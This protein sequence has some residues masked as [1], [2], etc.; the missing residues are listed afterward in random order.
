M[1]WMRKRTVRSRLTALV[2]VGSALLVVALSTVLW[3]NE[4]RQSSRRLDRS[5]ERRVDAID[6]ALRTNWKFPYREP[7][8]QAIDADYRILGMSQAID[9]PGL[10]TQSQIDFVLRNGGL[11]FRR[12]D[13]LLDGTARFLAQRRII[14]NVP[15]VVV[16]GETESVLRAS[17]NQ[18]WFAIAVGAPLLVL[19]MGLGGWALAGAVLRPVRKMTDDAA[20]ISRFDAKARLASGPGNDEL[21]HLSDTL[22]SMLDR[23]ESSFRRERSFVDDASHE[24]RTP[25]AIVRGELELALLNSGNPSETQDALQRSIDEV[26]RMIALANDLLVSARADAKAE[27]EGDPHALVE[28]GSWESTDVARLL[29]SVRDR[30]GNDD[31]VRF[32]EG[33]HVAPGTYV[34]MRADHLE[35]VVLNLLENARRFAKTTVTTSSRR[36]GEFVEIE[37]LDDGPGFPPDFI[38]RA[39]DRFSVASMARTR[40]QDPS[41]QSASGGV[42]LGLAIVADLIR[43]VGGS[44]SASNHDPEATDG[45]HSGARL[46]VSVPVAKPHE[47]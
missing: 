25:L 42:G 16:V 43:Q 19:L 46:I 39:F 10:L 28:S 7:Y 34:A 14:D 37:V 41:A 38:A 2:V 18:L 26:D 12:D 1:R 8:G 22:N 47:S 5:L 9:L 31:R 27:S 24:I 36:I 23:L 40:T 35:R 30:F 44:V 20:A 6:L 32:V 33:E 3:I 21:S 45:C 4:S 15:V 13:P 17:R 11:Q 29:D